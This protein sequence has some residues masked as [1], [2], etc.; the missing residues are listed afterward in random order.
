MKNKKIHD[1]QNVK[2]KR[3]L[4]TVNVRGS[5]GPIRFVVNDDDKVSEVIDSCLK[6]YARGGR[7]P[8]LG[9]DFNKFLLYPSNA[10]CEAMKA[11]E[12]IGSSGDRTF[13]M[14]KVQGRAQMG[15]VP[16]KMITHQRRSFCW[17]AW[18]KFLSH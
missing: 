15:D 18:F 5:P 8:I 10:A 14:Y 17:K 11:N 4:I 7:L 12:T 9:T 1:N 2:N 3:F 13:V 16:S 6:M